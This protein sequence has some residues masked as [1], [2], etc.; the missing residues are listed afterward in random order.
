MVEALHSWTPQLLEIWWLEPLRPWNCIKTFFD[1]IL[2]CASNIKKSYYS[3]V[4]PILFCSIVIISKER[5]CQTFVHGRFS[6]NSNKI[7]VGK[8]LMLCCITNYYSNVNLNLV[9]WRHYLRRG[10]VWFNFKSYLSC[11]A[12][13]IVLVTLNVAVSAC[14]KRNHLNVGGNSMLCCDKSLGLWTLLAEE[15]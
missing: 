7:Y 11:Y 10:N 12:I 1:W 14:N 2:I 8:F 5:I 13:K 4:N 9:L 15:H 3:N 6:W